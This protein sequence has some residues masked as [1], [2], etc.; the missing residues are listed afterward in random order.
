MKFEIDLTRPAGEQVTWVTLNKPYDPSPID[1]SKVRVITTRYIGSGKAG[2]GMLGQNNVENY[3]K[4]PLDIDVF[5]RYLK[6]KSPVNQETISRGRITIIDANSAN[7]SHAHWTITAL[8]TVL[9]ILMQ[10]DS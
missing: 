6:K 5:K 9:C 4:G 7:F 10:H 2:Y 1:S 8:C 3:K